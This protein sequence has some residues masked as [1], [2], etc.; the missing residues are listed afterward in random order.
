VLNDK[1]LFKGIIDK[2]KMNKWIEILLGLIFL[3]GAIFTWGFNLWNFGEAA[4]NFFKGGLVWMIILIGFI[5]IV[6]GISDLK[7]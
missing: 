7:D 4:L 3:N 6:L 5:F 1:N 2:S